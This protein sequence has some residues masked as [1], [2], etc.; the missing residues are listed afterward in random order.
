[1]NFN[2][3]EVLTR[4]WQI[5]WKHKVLWIFGIL[6]GCGRG[7]G[8]GSGG[9]QIRGSGDQPFPQL[10]QFFQQISQWIENN[11]WIV[12]VF[13]LLV[14]ALV[15][16]SI[17]LG[18]IGRISLIRGTYQ[19]DGGTERL[20]FGE[21]FSESMPYFWRVFGL[22]LLIF[23]I[24][25]FVFIPL[26]LGGALF[27]VVTAGIGAICLLPLICLL[28]PL[29][30]AFSV[31][32]E[33]ANVAI[34]LENLSIGDGFRKGWEVVRANVGPILVLTL[35][36]FIGSGVLGFFIAIP[37]IAAVAPLIF[38]A[39]NNTTG[40]IWITVICCALYFPIL[41]VLSGILNAYVQS[42]WTLTY[43]RLTA[44]PP[45]DNPPVVL[46]ANA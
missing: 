7:G 12:A 38:G 10:E 27:S 34:V 22:S 21:L 19:A 9:G 36:I 39:A 15:I 24:A 11:P 40:P 14:I 17:F 1:M 16:L 44:K 43:M 46:E 25:L 45:L 42:V 35:I 6:A 23:L 37:L 18:T 32:I 8:G 31:V 28:I 3:G 30:W 33:Q 4:A 20:N 41:L 2:F 5:I 29:L 26:A 13:I